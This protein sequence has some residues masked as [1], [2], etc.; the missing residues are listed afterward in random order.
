MK[1]QP[2]FYPEGDKICDGIILHTAGGVIGGDRL[3]LEIHL[4]PHSQV[5][6]TTATVNQIYRT[7]A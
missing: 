7:K 6:I 1:V 2:P 5:L 3:S 4:Q